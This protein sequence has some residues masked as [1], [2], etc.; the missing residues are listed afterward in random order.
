[1]INTVPDSV[2]SRLEISRECDIDALNASLG[3]GLLPAD[4][5][6]FSER[7]LN[8]L[9]QILLHGKCAVVNVSQPDH[10]AEAEWCYKAVY[11]DNS[12]V[13]DF[14]KCPR[15]GLENQSLPPTDGECLIIEAWA[16]G[17]LTTKEDYCGVVL[18][19]CRQDGYKIDV[20]DSFHAALGSYVSQ[21]N[22]VTKSVIGVKTRFNIKA[23]ALHLKRGGRL[24]SMLLRDAMLEQTP[25]WRFLQLYRILEQAYLDNIL[26]QLT[27]DFFSTAR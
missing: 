14:L 23:N 9:I 22:M 8:K 13:A 24:Y 26:E 10:N 12:I 3:N 27:E 25:R 6:V 2:Y 21:L 11:Q 1:M 4:V 19:C 16:S 20:L 17:Q 18:S 15:D 5:P 7:G